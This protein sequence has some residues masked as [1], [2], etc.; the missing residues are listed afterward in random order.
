ML[1]DSKQLRAKMQADEE[2]MQAAVRI[3]SHLIIT[4]GLL[5]IA[6]IFVLSYF[7]HV[8]C[9]ITLTSMHFMTPAQIR[10]GANLR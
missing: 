6:G 9:L 7:M 2:Q 5:L 3:E 8:L 10:H 4:G 1:L